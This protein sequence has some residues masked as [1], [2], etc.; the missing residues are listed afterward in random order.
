MAGAEPCVVGCV[1]ERE[2]DAPAERLVGG[3]VADCDAAE[4]FACAV[5]AQGFA[6]T[7]G[8]GECDNHVDDDAGTFP[9]IKFK[10]FCTRK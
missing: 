5:D 1:R 7:T 10:R 3:I 6:P 9:W 4:A 2:G 8:V